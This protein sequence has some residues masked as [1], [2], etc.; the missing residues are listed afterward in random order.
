MRPTYHYRSFLWPA[1]LILVGVIALLANTGQIPAE[2]LYNLVNLW[3]L[4]LVVI[5]LELIVRRSLHGV[6]GDIAAA[7]II[8][9]AIA[10]ATAY[11]AASPAAHFSQTLD[12]SAELGSISAAS[13]EIDAGAAQITVVGSS[14]LGSNLYRAHIDYSGPKPDVSLDRETGALV[15]T[16]GGNNFFAFGQQRFALSLQLN[17]SVPWTISQATGAAT[18]TFNLANV[19]LSRLSISTGASR[20]D[21]TLGPPSGKVS[22]QIN[23]G[24]LTVRVHRPSAAQVSVSVS[25]GA[26]SLAA[27]GHDYHGFGTLNFTSSSF[28]VAQDG[29]RVEVNGGACNVTVDQAAPSG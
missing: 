12:S 17:P 14:D 28:D 29:Y 16:Q 4:I 19:H 11:V 13:V 7:L 3:P 26:I 6:A 2:R 21:I 1:L 15:I 9:L 8:L 10:G 22:V 20:N 18:S 5:G 23:G 24:S 27:D 25:G